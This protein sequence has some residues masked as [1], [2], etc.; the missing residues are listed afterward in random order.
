MRMRTLLAASAAGAM[1]VSCAPPPALPATPPPL[2]APLPAPPPPPPPAPA[3]L[4]WQ[5]A[6]LSPGDWS[7]SGQSGIHE[8]TF[9]SPGG[10][11]FALR[12]EPGGQI[13]MLR[14]G[15]SAAT[16]TVVT[17]YGQRS[18]PSFGNEDQSTARLA[19]ADP[20]FDQIVF[21]RGRFLVRI[22]GGGD[23]I[24]P[25]WPEPARVVEECRAQ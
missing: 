6:P 25:S 12:C 22:A 5:D 13:A 20:L 19:A 1:A 10:P 18:L 24:L 15:A 9:A 4:G 7:Y 21:S 16:M 17:S 23:L 2:P 14:P 3:P 11:L 8:A